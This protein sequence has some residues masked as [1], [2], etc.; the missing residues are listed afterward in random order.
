MG[1]D[2]LIPFDFT[3]LFQVV[4]ILIQL[5]LNYTDLSVHLIYYIKSHVSSAHVSLTPCGNVGVLGLVGYNYKD[6]S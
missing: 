6:S 5:W 2:C 4:R 1:L 3:F